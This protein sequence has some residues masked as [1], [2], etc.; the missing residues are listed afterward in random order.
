MAEGAEFDP[1][2]NYVSRLGG[3]VG[4]VGCPGINLWQVVVPYVHGPGNGDGLLAANYLFRVLAIKIHTLE[5]VS[6]I[7]VD[8]LSVVFGNKFLQRHLTALNNSLTSF[9]I[10]AT[11]L[12][13][14]SSRCSSW[15]NLSTMAVPS[16]RVSSTAATRESKRVKR[17]R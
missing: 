11:S 15:I 1:P 5:P 17:I 3:I 2:N 4:L 9:F 10:S 6:I 8:S 14:L 12:T 13:R 16:F 7:P